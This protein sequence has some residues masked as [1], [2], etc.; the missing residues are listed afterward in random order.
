MSTSAP[1]ATVFLDRDGVI[2]RRIIDDYVTCREEMVLLAG[3]PEALRALQAAGYR[4]AVVTNQR[5][6]A[7]G[8]MTRAAVDDVHL[9]LNSLLAPVGVRLDDI[10][11][12][13][14]DRHEGCGCRKPDPGL[15]DQAN[16]DQPVDWAAS[17]LVGDSD[18]D[19]AA[20]RARAVTT[21]KVA[22]DGDGRAD[23]I[24]ADLPAAVARI[25][26]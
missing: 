5:G 14:H 6:I 12:C 23:W 16:R 1:R 21:I 26:A 11:V 3:V 7:V 19:I 25:L 4:L 8:R 20:G 10:Y 2:N 15:L 18:S 9:Y 24:V 13:P 22:G 17:F